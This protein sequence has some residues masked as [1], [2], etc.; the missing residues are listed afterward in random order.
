MDTNS[1]NVKSL[2]LKDV[3]KDL[4]EAFGTDYQ[5]N[6]GIYNLTIPEKWGNGTIKGIN[7]EGGLGVIIYDCSFHIDTK[8]KFKVNDIHPLKFI[9]CLEGSLKHAFEHDKHDHELDQYQ[10]CIIASESHN[11]HVLH[12]KANITIKIGSL[13]IDRKK[14]VAKMDCEVDNLDKELKKLFQDIDATHSFYYKGFYSLKMADLFR[15]I[16]EFD[17]N[18]FILKLYLEGKAYQI[19]SYQ[20]LQYQDDSKQIGNRSLLRQAEISL[21]NKAARMIE[22]DIVGIESVESISENIGLNINKLQ[23]G[24]KY[25]YNTTVNGYIHKTRLDLAKTLLINTDYNI[26]DIVEQIGL[27]SKSYFS[28]IFKESYDITPSEFRQ[29]NRKIIKERL[30]KQ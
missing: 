1:I 16:D 29:N 4:A 26:S 9:Y 6:C 11:G 21:I 19:C 14:F 8:I 22:N 3:I 27:S 13:E 23:E 5:E 18:D 15:K 17:N 12:F 10:S 20:I 25:M 28:K 7:F 30:N 24:F 2:P